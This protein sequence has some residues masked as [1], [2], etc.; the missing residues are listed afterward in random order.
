MR[1]IQKLPA[2]RFATAEAMAIELEELLAACSDLRGET[3]LVQALESAGLVRPSDAGGG[4]VPARLERASLRHAIL[5]L[6]ALGAACVAGAAVLQ[7]TAD[8][9]GELAGARLL[10]LLP[11]TPGYLRVLATP[12]AEVWVDGQRVD[13]TPFARAIPLPEGTHYVTLVHPSAP[14]EKR[15]IAIVRGETR[16]ID[17]VMAV[18]RLAP[19]TDAGRIDEKTNLDRDKR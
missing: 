14:T 3:L 18:P 12:W 8:R 10:D 2:D 19:A 11:P 16:T 5:G 6:A 9:G 4:A 17:V 13:V 15:T 7:V 1:A